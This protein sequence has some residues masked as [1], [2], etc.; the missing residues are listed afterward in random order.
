MLSRFTVGQQY[1]P[2]SGKHQGHIRPEKIT[3]IAIGVRIFRYFVRKAHN[4]LTIFMATICL[5]HVTSSLG[6][7]PPGET[8]RLSLLTQVGIN[9]AVLN[10]PGQR[11]H[12][13]QVAR[14]YKRVQMLL[15]DE[16]MG[17]TERPCKVGVFAMMCQLISQCENL[18]ELY[19]TAIH[20]YGLITD[21]VAFT[22][23]QRNREAIFSFAL[24]KPEL[25]S[26]HFLTEF[27]P[28][29]WHRFASWYIGEPI[30][31]REAHFVFPPPLHR[32]ELQI[33]FP[34]RLI[35]NADRNRLIFSEQYL[36]KPL[37]RSRL[38]LQTYLEN[39]PAD[40]MTIPGSD[41]T[42]EAQ[43]ERMVLQ[44]SPRQLVFPTINQ[45]A[46]EL[47]LSPQ[48]LHRRLKH[49][50]TSYQEIKNN[51]RREM[52]IQKLVKEQLPVLEVAEIVGFSE[53]RSFTR[54]FKQW[55][56]LSPRRYCKEQQ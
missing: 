1:R 7:L 49:S 55:T 27:L 10:S 6:G 36:T 16:F 38:E 18:R 31:L 39:Y 33:M 21:A 2:K 13:E 37:I 28:V 29:T 9:P 52:A 8:Q 56:G 22:L 35:F 25:D 14:L 48:T 30:R 44:R 26:E 4:K 40:I 12:T 3:F 50:G 46:L 43:I 15:D 51:M 20:C 42:L 53:P 11:V 45:L 24:A 54:A 5:H 47:N 19:Q 23:E 17:F 32:D 41:S 34:A